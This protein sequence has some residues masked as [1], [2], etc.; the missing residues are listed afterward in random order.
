MKQKIVEKILVETEKGYDLIFGKFSA[1]RKNFWG[2]LE[3]IGGYIKKGDRVFD[4]GCG[5]GRLSELF[6][7]KNIEYFGADVSEKLLEEGRKKYVSIFPDVSF[8]KIDPLQTSLPFPDDYFN[9]VYSIAV[10]HHFPG[11]KYREVMAKELFRVCR[12][13]GKAVITV[14]NLWPT[15]ASLWR[16]KQK[17]YHKNI[18][19]NWK[20]KILGKSDLDWNDCRITFT[21]NEGKVFNRYHHAFTLRELKVLFSKVGF[22]VLEAKKIG[23]NLVVV[24]EK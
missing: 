4:F 19:E 12:P 10:F 5:N 17:K 22:S 24:L 2:S 16:G 3:S 11:D 1:T 9:A 14:W 23:H 21:N 18:F 13:G 20:N 7:G 15:F 6:I 8:S